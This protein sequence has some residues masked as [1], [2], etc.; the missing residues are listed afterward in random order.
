M[1]EYY[2]N[3]D[4]DACKQ[5][6]MCHGTC[7]KVTTEWVVQISRPYDSHPEPRWYKEIH[8]FGLPHTDE[9]FGNPDLGNCL[10]YTYNYAVNEHPNWMNY[11]KLLEF[12]GAV[13][14]RRR[15]L[16]RG[17]EP[18]PEAAAPPQLNPDE[19]ENRS[20]ILRKMHK[21]VDKLAARRD[22]NAHEDGWKLL[23]RNS[24]GE[25]HEMEFDDG[26]KVRVHMLL[27]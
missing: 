26:Y 6:T 7:T 5:Y 10:D 17:F 19:K 18:A 20:H 11:D 8:G 1:N 4:I 23:H 27:A 22:N 9:I 24:F 16:L 14:G 21:A 3:A 13:S 25:E 15:G 12:Y 2:L